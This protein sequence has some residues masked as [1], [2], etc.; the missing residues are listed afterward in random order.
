MRVLRGRASSIE[1][2][3][4]ITDSLLSDPRDSAIRVWHPHRHVAFGPRD[5][6]AEG[7][8]RAAEAAKDLH[9]EPVERSVGGRA[10]A[11]TGTTVSFVHVD[12]VR[13]KRAGLTDRYDRIA[14]QLRLALDAVGIDADRGEPDAAFCPG[15]HSLS[16]EGKIVGLAQRV[17]RNAA[18]TAG[19]VIPCD[20]EELVDIL[21]PVYAHLQIPFDPDAV[22][23]VRHA[24]SSA[25]PG[26][27]RSAV[28]EALVSGN[29]TTP[30]EIR[31]EHVSAFHVEE[32]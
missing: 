2:D 10:V 17:R 21:E 19:I 8:P 27:V 1:R 15:S 16:A 24:G 9:Y 18:L 32:R 11:Y 26:D 14:D 6:R 3:R 30:S 7:Y 28:E 5:V 23:S 20:R 13:N 31:R 22:G 25:S 4:A 29:S 12:T